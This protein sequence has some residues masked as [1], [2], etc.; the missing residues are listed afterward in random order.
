MN[1]YDLLNQSTNRGVDKE[2]NKNKEINKEINENKDENKNENKYD[3]QICTNCDSISLINYDG[4]IVCNNCGI[5]INSIIN[6][7]IDS[8]YYGSDDC[9]FS[10]DPSRIG[11]P[12]NPYA[13]KS[14]LGTI[15]LGHGNQSFRTLHKWYS[16]NYKE[17]SLLKAFKTMEDYFIDYGLKI[18]TNII[19]K[20]KIFYNITSSYSIKRGASR[21]ASMAVS[22]Y[23]ACK[24]KNYDI[25]KEKLST[26]FNISKK[27]ITNSCKDFHDIIY[28]TQKKYTSSISPITYDELLPVFTKKL[29]LDNKYAII[30]LVISKFLDE[31]GILSENTPSSIAIGTLYYVILHYNINLSKKFISEKCH[32]SEVTI[33]KTTQKMKNN[34]KMLEPIFENVQKYIDINTNTI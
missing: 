8:R 16:T 19:D 5:I 9:K 34:S 14:S 15:I 24:L 33:S 17:R 28:N 27:K 18:P 6:Y 2:V 4:S 21:K 23:Y 29:H 25:S 13:P 11:I 20:A 3:H 1:Y 30:A 22:V 7:N 12:I 26:I 31:I 10:R 32:I